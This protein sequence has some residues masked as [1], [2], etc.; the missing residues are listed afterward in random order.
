MEASNVQPLT[1]VHALICFG[2]T[3]SNAQG[4]HLALHSGD[5]LTSSGGH[6]GRQGS[7]PGHLSTRQE[8]YP[9][10]Y[11]TTLVPPKAMFE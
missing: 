11:H 2:T 6:M 10:Y 7:N 4:V 8:P 5:Q 1:Y 3:P 9:L